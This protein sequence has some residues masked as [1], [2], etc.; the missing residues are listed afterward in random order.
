MCQTWWHVVG[1]L[2]L[3][4][5]HNSQM[6]GIVDCN[7][8]SLMWLLLDLALSLHTFGASGVHGC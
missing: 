5:G 8:V 4:M 2:T 7:M 6:W 3:K 1:S